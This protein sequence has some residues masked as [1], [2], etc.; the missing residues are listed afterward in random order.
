MKPYELT[1]HTEDLDRLVR[2]I[3]STASELARTKDVLEAGAAELQR[4]QGAAVGA[5]PGPRQRE[6]AR[7]C[8]SL[9]LAL[10]ETRK[11]TRCLTRG[12]AEAEVE[13]KDELKAEA[14]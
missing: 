6:L 7:C 8:L 3:E 10:E 14:A 11:W 5:E 13:A 2:R 1:V 12:L 4:L 9:E